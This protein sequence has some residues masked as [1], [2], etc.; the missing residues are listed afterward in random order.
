MRKWYQYT[1]TLAYIMVFECKKCFRVKRVRKK[2]EDA[3]EI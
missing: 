3:G 1:T 2:V